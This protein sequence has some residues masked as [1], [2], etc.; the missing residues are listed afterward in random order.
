M[1]P[2]Q[3]KSQEERQA[4]AKKSHITRKANKE[5]R[6]ALIESGLL[7]I[8]GLKKE[9]AELERKRDDLLLAHE[10]IT[11][12]SAVLNGKTLLCENFIAVNAVPY[13]NICGIYFLVKDYRV[14]Y[15]GQSKQ[16][17][18][19]IA[20]HSANKDF[21]SIAYIPCAPDILDK[22]ESL[23]IHTLNPPLNGKFSD[24][25]SMAPIALDAL[26]SGRKSRR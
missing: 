6:E 24:G 17:F 19:R 26:L 22:L 9:I 18:A 21:D 1:N 12:E 13:T 8:Y 3:T 11:I 5:K 10:L 7:E 2:M 20:T 4:I 14:V 25:R 16:V 23:Y 15:V